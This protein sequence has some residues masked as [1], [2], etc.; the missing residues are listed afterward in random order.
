MGQENGNAPPHARDKRGEF[1]KGHPP[2]FKHSIDPLQ[3]DDWL[4]A[5]ERQ[6]VI[7]Q[8]DDKEKILYASR[9]LQG[10]ALDLWDSF[11]FSHT[12]ANPI[13]WAKFCSAFRT[14][15]VPAGLMK[16][17]EFLALKQGSMTVAE[18]RDKFIQLSWYAPNEVDED[19]KRQELFMEGLNDGLQYQLLSHTFANFQ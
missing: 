10:A 18:Y 6:L 7:A 12:E 13:T 4:R 15:H 2:I 8:C 1:P 11:C 19:G 17:K 5:I 3:A 9:Q 14:H 16:L